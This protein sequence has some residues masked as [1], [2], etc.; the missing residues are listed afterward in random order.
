MSEIRRSS[1]FAGI[2]PAPC[3]EPDGP[4]PPDPEAEGP[5]VEAAATEF[6]DAPAE[7]GGLRSWKA[8]KSSKISDS[9]S[10][11]SS[12][13]CGKLSYTETL[14]EVEADVEVAN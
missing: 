12:E 2:E 10:S 7:D 9:I 6:E 4:P 14:L 11:F 3:P 1:A 5:A 13:N 8:I